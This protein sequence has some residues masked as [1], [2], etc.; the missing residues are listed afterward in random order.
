MIDVSDGLGGDAGHLAAA[1]GVGLRIEAEALPLQEGVVEVARRFG[2][3]P[4]ELAIGGGE[5]Y[6]LLA[7]LPAAGLDLEALAAAAGVRVT[8]IGDVVDG[9]GVEI[10]LPGGPVLA[11]AGFDQLD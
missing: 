5:D 4:L 3:D 9:S 2:R 10:R 6:E 1:G 11:A 8:R 7:A